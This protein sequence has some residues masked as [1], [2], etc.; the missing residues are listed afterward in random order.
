MSEA[1]STQTQ[2]T[3]ECPFCAEH[4][5]V[6]AKKCRHCGETIDVALRVAEEAKRQV[7]SGG[8]GGGGGGAASSATTVVIQD[9]SKNSNSDSPSNEKKVGFWLGA[10]I[11]FIPII[12]AWFTLGKGYSTTARVVSFVWMAL[13][14]IAIFA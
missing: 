13:S 3:Q 7:Q 1:E 2:Q 6:R 10:G 14:T 5:S 11:F 8:G 4:I 12:F 9:S